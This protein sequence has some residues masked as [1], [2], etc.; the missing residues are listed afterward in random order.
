MPTSTEKCVSH[1]EVYWC[2]LYKKQVRSA[3][4]IESDTLLLLQVKDQAIKYSV[5]NKSSWIATVLL[6]D[7]AIL[8]LNWV[9]VP[10][11]DK[12]WC[13]A[14]KTI[15]TIMIS[16]YHQYER[17]KW[18]VGSPQRS[19]ANLEKGPKALHLNSLSVPHTMGMSS[20]HLYLWNYL[21]AILQTCIV[22]GTKTPMMV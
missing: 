5:P 2:F 10:Y 14:I 4:Q 11:W 1:N 7:K 12:K 13:P 18:H 6:I 15:Q 8:C 19:T 3:F 20:R 9:H 21:R 22:R 16:K 17:R